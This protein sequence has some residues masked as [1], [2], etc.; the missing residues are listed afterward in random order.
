[1]KMKE[2]P[3]KS[4]RKQ[5]GQFK[6]GRSGNPA[7][8][9]KGTR[10]AA[11]VALDAIGEE[12]AR[13]VLQSVITAAQAGDMRAA[14][15]ILRRVWPERKGRAVVLDLPRITESGH[16][17]EALATITDAAARGEITP[18]EAS[19]LAGLVEGQRR[20]IETTDL[21]RRLVALEQRMEANR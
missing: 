4:E 3:E 17:V 13:T 20:A 21:E 15:V 12:S 7:G 1:M 18:D 14:E 2:M 5:A 6:P 10:N 16:V 8:K 9:P 19:A 11:L